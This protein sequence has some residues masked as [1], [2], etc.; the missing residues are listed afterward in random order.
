MRH[1]AEPQVP[2]ETVIP[3]AHGGSR[4]LGASTPRCVVLHFGPAEPPKELFT[5]L[6][7]RAVEVDFVAHPA[8]AMAQLV[9]A[10]R[11]ARRL[12]RMPDRPRPPGVILVVVDPSRWDALAAL[13][14]AAA[15]YAPRAALWQYDPALSPRLGALRA[16]PATGAPAVGP[17]QDARPTHAARI[18]APPAPMAARSAESPPASA[19]ILRLVGT[20]VEAPANRREDAPA[21]AYAPTPAPF[22][23]TDELAANDDH[24]DRLPELTP[25]ELEALLHG[26]LGQRG[27]RGGRG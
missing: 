25:T 9:I 23:I 21:A 27:E 2:E 18:T 24:A 15:K 5:A 26:G 22:T 8:L 19:P 20:P 13:I 10:E 17:V 16:P 3:A 1:Q 7:A 6:A 4:T 12:A 11:A 14:D